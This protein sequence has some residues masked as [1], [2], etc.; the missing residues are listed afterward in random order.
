MGEE[1]KELLSEIIDKVNSL[2]GSD[3]KEDDKVTFKIVEDKLISNDELTKVLMGDNSDDVK[4][5]YFQRK[6]K[7]NVID[8]YSDKFE[9]YKMIMNDKIFPQLVHHYFR[10]VTE[11][12]RK[13]P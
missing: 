3:L 5:D 11:H 1:E 9:L 6:V 10:T 7:D 12:H 2:F 4:F 8:I 13:N